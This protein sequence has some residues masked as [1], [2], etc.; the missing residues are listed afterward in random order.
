[1]KELHVSST[2]EAH[3]RLPSFITCE[4]I[5][6]GQLFTGIKTLKSGFREYP[7]DM[8]SLLKEENE[9]N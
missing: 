6:Y 5:C 2:Q 8:E 9:R 4:G 3:D 1:M 7:E